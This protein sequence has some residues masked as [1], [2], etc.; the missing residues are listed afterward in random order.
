MQIPM[1]AI[2]V[3]VDFAWQ[4]RRNFYLRRLLVVLNCGVQ[5]LSH[6]RTLTRLN[7]ARTMA[8]MGAAPGAH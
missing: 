7:H 2:L 8:T 3:V 4:E 5:N 6:T 1:A